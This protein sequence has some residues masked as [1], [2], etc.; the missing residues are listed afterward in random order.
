M[1]LARRVALRAP[2][3]VNN[4]LHRN[5]FVLGILAGFAVTLGVLLYH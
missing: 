2:V 4:W 3:L 5:A 1:F